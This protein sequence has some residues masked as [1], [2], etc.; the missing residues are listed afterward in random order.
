MAPL[1]MIAAGAPR[2]KE[3]AIAAFDPQIVSN[4]G[5]ESKIRPNQDIGQQKDRPA[6]R[7]AVMDVPMGVWEAKAA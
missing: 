5:V 3:S 4:L 6:H 1:T 2:R 7:N